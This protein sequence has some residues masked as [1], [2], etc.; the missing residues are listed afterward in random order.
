M[1]VVLMESEIHI[2]NRAIEFLNFESSYRV[3]FRNRVKRKK[4]HTF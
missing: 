3:L 4:V 2:I 1:E